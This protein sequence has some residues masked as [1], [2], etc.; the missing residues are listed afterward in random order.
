MTGPIPVLMITYNRLEYTKKAVE[1]LKQCRHAII[2]IIDNG[3]DPETIAYLKGEFVFDKA[4]SRRNDLVWLNSINIGIAGA[5]NQFLERTM[6]YNVVAKVDNDTV[7]PP[8]FL[9]KMIPHLEKADIV[10]AKHHLIQASGVG[11][12]DEWTSTMPADGALRYNHFVGGSGILFKR[13]IVDRLPVTEHKL[14][15]WRQWQREHPEFKKAFATDVEV[16]LLDTD[17]TGARYE[18]YPDYYKST[19][20]L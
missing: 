11:S 18:Q 2:Y 4:W 13:K 3:S 17:E 9:E 15:G 12:F 6:I 5:M 20:R 7:V 8:D 19:G 14:M 10:Q 1:A 16:K